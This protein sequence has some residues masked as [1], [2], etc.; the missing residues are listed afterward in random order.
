MCH[1]TMVILVA[2]ILLSLSIIFFYIKTVSYVLYIACIQ[3]FDSV[4]VYGP[5]S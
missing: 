5:G 4:I 3:L 2:E 1:I